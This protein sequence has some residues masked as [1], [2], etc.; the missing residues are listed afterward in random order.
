[1]KKYL[2]TYDVDAEKEYDDKKSFFKLI[3]EKSNLN[4]TNAFLIPL[5]TENRRFN[6]SNNFKIG[7]KIPIN[8]FH[9][10]DYAKNTSSYVYVQ[11]TKDDLPYVELSE[12]TWSNKGNIF[13]NSKEFNATKEIIL[14][15]IFPEQTERLQMETFELETKKDVHETYK[16]KS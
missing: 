12:L 15:P 9:F 3:F 16:K 2:T 11:Q 1:M 6:I 4:G 8:V 14:K 5:E 10:I 13:N 7:L